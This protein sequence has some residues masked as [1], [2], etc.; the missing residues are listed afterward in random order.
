M[1]TTEYSHMMLT[2]HVVKVLT[3]VALEQRISPH[4]TKFTDRNGVV[5]VGQFS[6]LQAIKNQIHEA[7]IHNE[8]KSHE[9]SQ[10]NKLNSGKPSKNRIC[11]TNNQEWHTP[12]QKE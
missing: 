12:Y 9:H 1:S 5:H 3:D 4:V 6:P 8:T 2:N 11:K 7:L 10:N